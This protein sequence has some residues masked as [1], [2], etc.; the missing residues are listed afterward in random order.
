MNISNLLKTFERD[1][2]VA[3]LAQSTI[4]NYLSQ[5][6]MFLNSHNDRDSAKHINE[7]HIKNYLLTA[8]E[9]NSQRAMHS[10]I[11][12]FYALTV[13]QPMKFRYIPYARKESKL[14]I[15]FT[16]D[17]MKR[18]FAVQ[19]NIKHRAILSLLYST[20]MRRDE[21][22]SLEW[23]HIHRNKHTNKGYI[24]IHAGKGAKDRI[25]TLDPTISEILI[26]YYKE[27]KPKVF[28]FESPGGGKYSATSVTKVLQQICIK[29]GISKKIKPH[30]IRHN[31]ATHLLEAG[32]DIKKL[33]DLLGHA[34][35]AT[36]AIY[37]HMSN[38]HV[39]NLPTPMAAMVC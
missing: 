8:Q 2:Q 4:Q 31:Y 37:L 12:K 21:L 7:E 6:E 18:M 25:V 36:T 20:G 5:V 10:A 24:H 30:L 3:N 14:P 9:V 23:S 34:N 32:M 26:Q 16:V 1:M 15:I 17:E 35:P 11:K 27:Y 33:Q 13:K 39:S 19:M 29:A 28:V 38:S 22:L